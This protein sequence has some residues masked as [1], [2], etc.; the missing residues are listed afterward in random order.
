MGRPS[1][2]ARQTC[3]S[4]TALDVRQLHRS[5]CL[6]PGLHY[7]W[8]WTRGNQPS[9]DIKIMTEG[10]AIWLIFRVRHYGASEWRDIRQRV[11]LTWTEVHLGGRRPWFQCPVSSCGKY[12]GRRV[13]KLY[14]GGDLFACRHC[15]GLAYESQQ[16]S[17]PD[18]GLNKA[19]KIRIR[20]GGSGSVLERFPP[21]PKG[22]HRRTYDRLRSEHYVAEG[23]WMEN[24]RPMLGGAA[25]V[26]MLPAS[27]ITKIRSKKSVS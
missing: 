11:H 18:P 7:S 19:Q 5:D 27:R 3:E 2:G 10:D 15:W 17:D 25:A 14:L 12:C 8:K 23:V 22:M 26:G 6:R 4:C 1:G 16:D 13:A 21:R 9:G 20:L 24:L